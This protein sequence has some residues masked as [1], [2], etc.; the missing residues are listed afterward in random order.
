MGE[1]RR[2]RG[3]LNREA[4]FLCIIVYWNIDKSIVVYYNFLIK[5]G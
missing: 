1:E 2:P 3:G 4:V 5:Q